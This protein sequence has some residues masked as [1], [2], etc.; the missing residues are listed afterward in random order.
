MFIQAFTKGL[1]DASLNGRVLEGTWRRALL[2]LHDSVSA[3]AGC[4]APVYCDLEVTGQQ[5]WHCHGTLPAP[6]AL[7][8]PGGTLVLSEGAT[9][10]SH[11]LY[12]D[13]Q[14]R[15]ACATVEPYPGRPGHV[16]M[17]NLTDQIWTVFAD[18]EEPK[19]VAP[20]QRLGVRPMQIDFGKARGR[21]R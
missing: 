14:Y 16:V 3:C 12:R 9:L 11:H 21:I 20:S 4:A 2:S 10:S 19:R 18:G 5:C 6:P 8:A 15:T 7:A 13:H 1:H 17:R